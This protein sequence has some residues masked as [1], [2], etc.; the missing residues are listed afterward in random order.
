MSLQVLMEDAS[1]Q[2]LRAELFR[3]PL[4]PIPKGHGWSFVDILSGSSG[5]L[6]DNMVNFSIYLDVCV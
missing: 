4:F 6:S 5:V 1:D 3:S 2:D